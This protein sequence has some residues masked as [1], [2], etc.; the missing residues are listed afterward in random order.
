MLPAPR[1]NHK[2]TSNIL[3]NRVGFL[4]VNNERIDAKKY[5]PLLI[6]RRTLLSESEKI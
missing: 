4:I 1:L 3:I 2:I 6:N 5:N